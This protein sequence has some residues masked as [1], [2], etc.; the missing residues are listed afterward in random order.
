MHLRFAVL[1]LAL[2]AGCVGASSPDASGGWAV[3]EV[4]SVDTAPMAYDG[5]AVVRLR[6]DAG[7][8]I[9]VHVPARTNLCAADGLGI[10]GD[11]R[12]GDWVE[13]RGTPGANGE[14]R[15]CSEADHV[16]RRVPS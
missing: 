16:L 2:A 11:L 4:V 10:V 13:V 15:P 3:G 1:L 14:I 12:P 6:T 8:T 7:E 9:T 5:D